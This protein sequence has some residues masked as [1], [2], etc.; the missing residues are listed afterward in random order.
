[1]TNINDLDFTKKTIRKKFINSN[2]GRYYGVDLTGATVRVDV[3]KKQD[4]AVWTPTH[5]KWYEIVYYDKQG[6][7]DS[8]TYKTL[9]SL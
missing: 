9:A 8:I 1:M 6:S 3:N 5:G 4:M 7:Q 2:D